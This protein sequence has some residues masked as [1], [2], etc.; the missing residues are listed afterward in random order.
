MMKMKY[1]TREDCNKFET[2]PGD[3]FVIEYEPTVEPNGRITIHPVGKK[4]LFQEIQSWRDQT[5]MH[6]V[7][8]QMALGQYPQ[9]DSVMYGDFTEAPENM[10]QAMQMMINAEIAFYQLPLEVRKQFDNDYKQWMMSAQTDYAEFAK[11]MG[12]VSDQTGST[13]EEPKGDDKE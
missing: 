12:F 8:Q 13:T 6:Y 10:Q 11:K 3:R 5:D 1:N 4:D 2:C 9:R 7:L